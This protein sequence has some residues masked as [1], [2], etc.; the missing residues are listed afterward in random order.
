MT[1]DSIGRCL[2][3][4]RLCM[5]RSIGDLELKETGVICE[6]DIK[7]VRVRW[8]QQLKKLIRKKQC[9]ISADFG[10]CLVI[11]KNYQVPSCL[12]LNIVGYFV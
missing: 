1:S 11:L 9:V 12:P 5:S 4:G 2:V 6:P 10:Y 3:N 7:Q 8:Y